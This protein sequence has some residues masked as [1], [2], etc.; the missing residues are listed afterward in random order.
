[1]LKRKFEECGVGIALGTVIALELKGY[2]H[3]PR[4]MRGSETQADEKSLIT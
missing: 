3:D 4:G 2:S 1:M